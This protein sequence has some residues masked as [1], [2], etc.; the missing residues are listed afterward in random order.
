MYHIIV[1]C[2]I[3]CAYNRVSLQ[4]IS[5]L[6]VG[7]VTL[8]CENANYSIVRNVMMKR[9]IHIPE[10]KLSRWIA[11][12]FLALGLSVLVNYTRWC[13]K[14]ISI[15]FR[16]QCT[17]TKSRAMST[18]AFCSLCNVALLKFCWLEFHSV[19]SLSRIVITNKTT[20]VVITLVGIINIKNAC[21][22]NFDRRYDQ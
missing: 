13:F 12:L 2:H 5:L 22:S 14:R 8:Y 18:L 17:H 16:L 7:F 9:G 20:S 19:C 6:T 3:K 10:I 21:D 1:A 15:K 11:S 4:W